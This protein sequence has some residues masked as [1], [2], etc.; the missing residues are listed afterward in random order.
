MLFAMIVLI[1]FAGGIASFVY[2]EHTQEPSGKA[3]AVFFGIVGI[4]VAILFGL[5][6]I[7]AIQSAK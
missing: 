6:L 3:W 2:Y 5:I 1:A 4:G 7:A